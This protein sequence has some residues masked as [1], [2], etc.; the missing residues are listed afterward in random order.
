MAISF[1]LIG[2]SKRPAGGPEDTILD[3]RLRGVGNYRTS[4][5]IAEILWK[6]RVD[7]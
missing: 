4:A 5:S 2:E 6:E 3:P 1:P 7:F